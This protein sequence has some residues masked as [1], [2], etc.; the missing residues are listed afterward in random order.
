MLTT[1]FKMKANGNY[2][3]DSSGQAFSHEHLLFILEAVG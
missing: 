2:F 1:M 3:L